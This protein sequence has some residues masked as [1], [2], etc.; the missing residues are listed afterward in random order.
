MPIIEVK[1]GKNFIQ[2]SEAYKGSGRYKLIVTDVGDIILYPK[3]TTKRVET[4]YYPQASREEM[5]EIMEWWGAANV[6]HCRRFH[7]REDR[8]PHEI[9][10]EE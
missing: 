4:I 9:K 6:W 7:W 3:V 10:K 1:N 2:W 8:N 5:R